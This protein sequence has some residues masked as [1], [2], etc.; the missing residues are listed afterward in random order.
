[1]QICTFSTS[2]ISVVFTALEHGTNTGGSSPRSIPTPQ[3]KQNKIFT[4]HNFKITIKV[5][6]QRMW[7]IP[8]N[9]DCLLQLEVVTCNPTGTKIRRYKNTACSANTSEISNSDKKVRKG[10][11]FKNIAF[12]IMPLVLQLHIMIKYSKFAVHIFNTTTFRFLHHKNDDSDH[13]QNSSTFLQNRQT[14]IGIQL[15]TFN[16]CSVSNHINL[17]AGKV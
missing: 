6:S 15:R 2:L 9:Q 7:N 1:M 12:S 14:K 5:K 13:R 11:N 8:S 3:K 17:W 4:S 16:Q 10:H